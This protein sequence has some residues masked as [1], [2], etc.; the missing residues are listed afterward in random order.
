MKGCIMFKEKIVIFMLLSA[1]FLCA[2]S[3]AAQPEQS[4]KEE[5]QPEEPAFERPKDEY[6]LKY[7]VGNLGGKPVKLPQTIFT[8]WEYDDSPDL[9]GGTQEE[10]KAYKK[11]PRT[12]D[13][14]IATMSFDMRYTDGMLREFYYK[15]PPISR[16][17]YDAEHDRL[18]SQ[19]LDISI[20]S[21][22][23]YAGG[24]M[25]I[26]WNNIMSRE[27]NKTLSY[28]PTGKEIYGLQEYKLDIPS[29]HGINKDLYV[30]KDKYGNA[31]TIFYCHDNQFGG[32]VNKSFY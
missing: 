5:V 16:E 20:N 30:Y 14:V 1:V 29:I 8:V 6:G 27:K 28:H 23:R 31:V 17:Q 24:D 18:D 10:M 3:P 13:S 25:N 32:G 9:W 21:G 26:Y 19:W 2:C 12:Y 22:R 11:R 15:A 4:K 7:W